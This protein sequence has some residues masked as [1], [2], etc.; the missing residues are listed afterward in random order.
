MVKSGKQTS[1]DRIEIFGDLFDQVIKIDLYIC[2]YAID[3][4]CREN[5]LEARRADENSD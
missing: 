1:D 4:C 2:I 3:C 5:S